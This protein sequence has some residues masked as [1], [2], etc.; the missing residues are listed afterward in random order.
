M[1]K[2]DLAKILDNIFLP[3]NYKKK[4]NYWVNNYGEII[5]MIN[6]Q[7][8][9]YSNLYYI[10]YGFILKSVPLGNNTMH[11][12]HRFGSS[13]LKENQRINELLDLEN[14]INDVERQFGLTNILEIDLV[15]KLQSKNSEDD[16]LADLQ[17]RPHLNDIPLV[18]KKHFGL[19]VD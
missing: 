12:Y 11:I 16:I 6:L 10:N 17:N 9:N 19:P 4:G 18:V 13:D 7:K 3:L 14:N 5:K 8:S 15:Q 2:K 1:E